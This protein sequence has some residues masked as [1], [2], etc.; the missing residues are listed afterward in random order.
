MYPEH[1]SR[2]TTKLETEITARSEHG[3]RTVVGNI[4]LS[5]DGRFTGA[6]GERDMS[7]MD[8]PMP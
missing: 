2:V 3:N 4:S 7:W 6:G 8:S 5:L 1:I